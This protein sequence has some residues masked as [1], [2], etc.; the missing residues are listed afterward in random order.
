MPPKAIGRTI[1]AKTKR[2]RKAAVIS[3]ESAKASCLKKGGTW[4]PATPTQGAICVVIPK[5]P[6]FVI[7]VN[8]YRGDPCLGPVGPHDR[9]ILVPP[10]RELA[11]ALINA[12]KH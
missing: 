8:R 9:Y 11:I 1:K 12:I 6:N 5:E 2:V 3:D 4:I 7:Q 10:T